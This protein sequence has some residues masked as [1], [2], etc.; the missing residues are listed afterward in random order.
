MCK[1]NINLLILKTWTRI[2]YYN[3]IFIISLK[4]NNKQH[5]KIRL[6]IWAPY[7]LLKAL[8]Y[9]LLEPIFSLKVK[10][11]KNK[12]KN[13]DFKYELGIVTIA[14]NEGPYIQEWIEFHKLVGVNRFYF[15]DNESNDNT[16]DILDKYIQDSIVK[17]TKVPGKA[18]QL[19][20]YNDAIF[21]YKDECRYLA[22]ID[23]DEYI[24]PSI[25]FKPLST[26]INEIIEHYG[27]GAAG[28][29][30]NWAMYGSSGHVNKPKGLITENYT[31]RG[32]NS[33][34]G[35]AHIKTICNPRFI[36]YYVSAHYPIY[37]LG[38]YSIDES[39]TKKVYVWF[40]DNCQYKNLRINHYF[41]KS[42]E[43]YIA[44]KNRGLADR[45]GNYDMSQFYKYDLNDVEDYIMKPYI[46][47][48]KNKIG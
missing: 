35:N 9:F 47:E 42:K 1:M 30:L 43:E 41:S 48:L 12:E 2:L 8:I 14:K 40:N 24:V 39:G 20:V 10:Y 34:F 36:S 21:K 19:P 46:P 4:R 22:F 16:R 45:E 3:N 7:I 17:Y 44:K 38:A 37:K 15:Y 32:E 18:Q 28:I 13:K 27:K 25:P 23:M 33:H 29:G 26:I 5:Y 11:L 31:R 6:L